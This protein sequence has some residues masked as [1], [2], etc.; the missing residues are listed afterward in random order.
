V[1]VDLRVPYTP[2]EVKEYR[3]A[4]NVET[5][6]RE[7]TY[8]ADG[9]TRTVDLF[10]SLVHG[11]R[12]RI[13]VQCLD[14]GQLIGMARPD[15]FIRTPD[16]PFLVGYSKAMIGI[17]LMLIL[18]IVIGVSASTFLKGPVATLLTLMF[19]LVGTAFHSFIERLMAGD[20]KGSGAV[21]S[22]IRLVRHLNPTSDLGVGRAGEAVSFMD[23]GFRAQLWIAYKIIPDFTS[24]ARTSE[25]V[26]NGFDVPMGAGLIPCF[27]T[28]LAYVIPCLV[29]GHFALKIRELEAK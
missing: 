15:L 5:V 26:S 16:R 24:F 21:E 14:A 13:E 11:D 23:S 7:L 8:S 20:V 12:L 28:T 9:Q 19:V 1:I 10:D 3:E 4:G 2:F 27:A 18:V 22:A 6:K 29:L 25:F 17:W